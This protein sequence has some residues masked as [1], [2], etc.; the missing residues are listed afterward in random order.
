MLAR[1]LL[2]HGSDQGTHLILSAIQDALKDT[3]GLPQRT[4]SIRYCTL[5]PDHGVMPETVYL[6]NLLA[7]SNLPDLSELFFEILKRI[8][9]AQRDWLDRRQG[10]Y[11]Y[12]ES[13]AYVAER[14]GD[15]AFIPL[16][17][18]LLQIPEFT[19]KSENKLL[20]E[21]YDMLRIR[22]LQALSRLGSTTGIE[23]L[24]KLTNDKRRPISLAA[25]QILSG[26]LGRITQKE[27]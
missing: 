8:L 10:I 5:L 9:N 18:Q 16:L 17:E 27:Y 1:L 11:C 15:G 14:R 7:W 19:T 20:T 13:F 6:L 12:I 24:R 3:D 4:G 23:G 21:R 2:Y 22:L 25:Q 26:K